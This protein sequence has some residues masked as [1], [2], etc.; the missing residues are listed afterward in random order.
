MKSDENETDA[1]RALWELRRTN[2]LTSVLLNLAPIGLRAEVKQR[3]ADFESRIV[4]VS[5]I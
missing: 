4:Q 5:Q 3:T 2:D 1:N